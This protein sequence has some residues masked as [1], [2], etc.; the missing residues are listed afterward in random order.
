MRRLA[1]DAA[2]LLVQ[3]AGIDD[4]LCLGFGAQHDQQVRH[5]GRPAL[6]VELHDAAFG[7]ALERHLHHA[8]RA[9]H[10]LLARA[11]DG[12]R[13]LPA[14]HRARDFRRVGEVR[15]PRVFD[16]QPGL[17]EAFL[18]LA[19]ETADDFVAAAAQRELGLVVVVES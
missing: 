14:Q 8:D 16:V 13:L 7:E 11:D 2:A 5:H 6:V 3:R 4:G 17:L 1:Q 9:E 12:F 15:E 10:D 18:Q 19:L